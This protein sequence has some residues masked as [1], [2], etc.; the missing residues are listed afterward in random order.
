[1]ILRVI[2]SICDISLRIVHFVKLIEY[3]GYSCLNVLVWPSSDNVFCNI[4]YKQICSLPGKFICIVCIN[5][6]STKIIQNKTSIIELKSYYYISSYFFFFRYVFNIVR[7]EWYLQLLN[8]IVVFAIKCRFRW[9][10]KSNF[11]SMLESNICEIFQRI[12]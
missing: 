10:I 2:S 12:C 4:I 3:W 1:M 5:K 6:M 8:D 7:Q 9:M 11:S